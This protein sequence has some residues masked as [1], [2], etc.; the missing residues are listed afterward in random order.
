MIIAARRAAELQR[1]F[2][3]D[4]FNAAIDSTQFAADTSLP[5]LASEA[6]RKLCL[7]GTGLS[8]GY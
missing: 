8:N 1:F 7:T 6:G 2:A 5:L 3:E 4:L